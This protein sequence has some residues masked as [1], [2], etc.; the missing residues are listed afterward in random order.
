MSVLGYQYLTPFLTRKFKMQD[1]CGIH[2]LHG[3]VR[4]NG[5]LME[6]AKSCAQ[7]GLIGS[8]LA[9]FAAIYYSR[10]SNMFDDLR[11]TRQVRLE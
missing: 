7:P 2:N 9:V 3:M 1:I 8:F 10:N 4:F 5:Q 6:G 11:G